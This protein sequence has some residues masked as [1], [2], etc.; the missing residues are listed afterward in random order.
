MEDEKKTSFGGLSGLGFSRFGGSLSG[1]PYVKSC[2]LWEY[3]RKGLCLWEPP[4]L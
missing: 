4:Y 2:C 1:S 3:I